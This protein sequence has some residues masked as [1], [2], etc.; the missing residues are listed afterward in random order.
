MFLRGT[1]RRDH[2]SAV[3][4]VMVTLPTGR[5]LFFPG[6]PDAAK[7]LARAVLTAEELRD[8]LTVIQAVERHGDLIVQ[9]EVLKAASPPSS[10]SPTP[11]V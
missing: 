11:T 10:P 2:R 3:P 1:E 7:V 9:G 5:S 4:G 6:S 8:P